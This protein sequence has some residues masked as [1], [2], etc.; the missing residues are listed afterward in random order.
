MKALTAIALSQIIAIANGTINLQQFLDPKNISFK[1]KS[2]WWVSYFMLSSTIDLI[3][4]IMP[5][6]SLIV[7]VSH[8]L[9][10]FCRITSLVHRLQL[11]AMHQISNRLLIKTSCNHNTVR[12]RANHCLLSSIEFLLI[13]GDH[14]MM[15]TNRRRP[16]SH[17]TIFPWYL[18]GEVLGRR[19]IRWPTMVRH[20]C[21]L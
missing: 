18:S 3:Y 2:T 20:I 16:L 14:T 6:S 4:Y 12:Q 8:T 13:S 21:I 19:C 5:V 17:R 10:A 15:T 9:H 1:N 11:Y 7:D